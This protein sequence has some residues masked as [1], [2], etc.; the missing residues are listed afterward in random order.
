[1]WAAAAEYRTARDD[2]DDDDG[3]NNNNNIIIIIIIIMSKSFRQYLSDKHGK[4]DIKELQT[5]AVLGTAFIFRK[6]IM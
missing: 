2:S 4:Q 5:T 3:N 6:V 1:V